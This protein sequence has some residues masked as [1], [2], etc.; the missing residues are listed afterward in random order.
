MCDKA[1]NTSVKDRMDKRPIILLVDANSHLV[2]IFQLI[3][4][5]KGF[6]ITTASSAEQALKVL[7]TERPVAI[8]TAL[9][10]PK[11]SGIEFIRHVRNNP[12]LADI[13]IVVVSSLDPGQLEKAEKAGAT[14][15]LR[16]PV[17]FNGLVNILRGF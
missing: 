10:M 11:M 5:S 15:V 3:L 4:T 12:E 7:E 2:E 1:L 13:P 9:K 8:I 16:K 6:S 14:V 17:D